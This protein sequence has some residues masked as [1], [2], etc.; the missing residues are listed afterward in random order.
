[1]FLWSTTKINSFSY[2]IS[3][4]N[5]TNKVR[6]RVKNIGHFSFEY[7]TFQKLT[8]LVSILALL[9]RLAPQWKH[10]LWKKAVLLF[11]RFQLVEEISTFFFF[12]KR[13]N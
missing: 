7:N 4:I 9:T 6:S 8:A 13:K 11:S 5:Q 2:I 10:K 3:V 12:W 1:M